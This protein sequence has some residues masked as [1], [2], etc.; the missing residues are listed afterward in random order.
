MRLSVTAN[1]SSSKGK[2]VASVLYKFSFEIFKGRLELVPK[3]SI[4]VISEKLVFVAMNKPIQSDI[5]EGDILPNCIILLA[6]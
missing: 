5:I 3:L 1:G 4:F 6:R 2:I